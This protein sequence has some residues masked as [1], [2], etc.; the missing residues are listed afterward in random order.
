MMSTTA[1]PSADAARNADVGKVAMK[2]EVVSIPVSDVD[3]AKAFY[4]RLGWRL[5]ADFTVGESHAIQFTPPG[6]PASIH[7]GTH[8]TPATP[9]SAQGLL[10]IV[11]DIQA[12]RDELVARGVQVSE[13]YH[14]AGFN[15]VDPAQRL[16]GPAP[17][18]RSYGSWVSFSDPDGNGWLVQ[19]ITTRL[20]GRVAGETRYTST[21]DL[22]DA[23]RRAAAAHGEHEKRNGGEYDANWP[24]WYAEYLVREQAGEAPPL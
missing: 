17:E 8:V 7:F 5:D 1:V 19:E 16:S 15:R 13:V 2:L 10:L 24:D 18:R 14:Y 11:S 21:G 12:A 3:R 23:L 6:S 20:P 22:A 9:G 4:G